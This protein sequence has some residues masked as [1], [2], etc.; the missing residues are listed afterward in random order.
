[1][2]EEINAYFNFVNAWSHCDVHSNFLFFMVNACRGAAIS[3]N[4]GTNRL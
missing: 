4:L 3:A 1:M 2:G